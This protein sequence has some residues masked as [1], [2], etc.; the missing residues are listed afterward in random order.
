MIM[1]AKFFLPLAVVLFSSTLCLSQ[2]Q[3]DKPIELTGTGA[4][5]RISGISEIAASHDAVNAEAI[6]NNALTFSVATFSSGVYT[7]N[8]TPTIV[9]LQS[10]LILH[11]LAPNP[12]TGA[13][14]LE[15]NGLP[16]KPIVKYVDQSL[17]ADDIR[18]GQLVSV[19]F[20]SANDRFQILTPLGAPAGGGGAAPGT[21]TLLH[22]DESA[23]SNIN[24][25]YSPCGTGTSSGTIKTY[26]LETNTYSRIIAEVGG[27]MEIGANGGSFNSGTVTVTLPGG[28]SK[29]TQARR[30][31][32]GGGTGDTSWHFPFS[33]SVSG[34]STSAGNVTVSGNLSLGGC[35]GGRIVVNTFRVYGVY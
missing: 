13:C 18:T 6:Q 24:V 3:I 1:K 25:V 8:P 35:T 30:S 15:V 32:T 20:D 11:F 28:A 2:V 9:Q 22:A 33:V 34:V 31:V 26:A 27:Y 4:D 17:E 10:G 14:S 16:A 29:S 12:N 5:G 21:V 7:V 23:T 19:M